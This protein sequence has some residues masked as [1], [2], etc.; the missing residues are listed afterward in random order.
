MRRGIS[1]YSPHSYSGKPKV[2]LALI[3]RVL[4][5]ARPYKWWLLSILAITFSIA[6]LSLLTPL[7]LRDLIDRT[8]PDRDIQRLIWLAI[9]LVVIPLV[10]SALDVAHKQINARVG[11]GIVYDLRS[12][13]FSHLQ[14][15]SLSFFTRT[16]SGELF[17]RLNNDVTG[18]Q[19]AITKVYISIITSF[20]QAVAILAVM[21]SLEWRLTLISIAVV[22]LFLLAARKLG[23]RLREI[24]RSQLDT[25]AKMNAIISELLNV[26]G[27]LLV[28]LFGRSDKENKRF[29]ERA[30]GVRDIGIKRAVT[31]TLFFTSIGLL[32]SIGVALVYGIG[33]YLVIGGALTIGTIVALGSYLGKLYSSLQN[34][35]NAPV[36]FATSIVSFERVF[37][38]LDLPLDIK[39]KPNAIVLHNIKGRLEFENVGFSY[40]KDD[41]HPLSEVHRFG[42]TQDV[43]AVLSED[44]PALNPQFAQEPEP[45]K[46]ETRSQ[47]REQALE[48]I[49][50][51][52]EP[53]QLVALVG[54]S[55]A[56][57][58][59]LTYLIPRLYD[60]SSGRI[61]I[62]GID[63]K[64]T[65]LAS[66]SAQI[67][68]VTQETFLFHDTVLT[69]LLYARPDA[70]SEQV[71]AAARAANI[72]DFIMELPDRYE[73]LV[74]ERGYRLSG[75]EKQRMALAR[76]ILKDP[77]ILVLDEATSSLDS[78]SEALIQEAL[79]RV[80]AERTSIVIAHRL[81]TILSADQI[82][83]MNRGEIVERGTHSRLL[84][85][86]GVYSSLYETQFKQSQ[87]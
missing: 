53:G 3:K 75:G 39:E 37:E 56:G 14:N 81:S 30:A 71:K 17:S 45:E 36:D 58:T 32:S 47:A 50:F 70:S 76:V 46:L 61:L 27:A 55:G 33:G 54:P 4:K 10:T 51:C 65:N 57:K 38:V 48:G 52:A 29:Q 23:N 6:G 83:V 59:T 79:G 5:Y 25:V 20:V 66:L 49:S 69:N 35:T 15:M 1:T 43:G 2:D 60:P 74:G 18:A 67:G 40:P 21:V 87:Q 24:T 42:V 19:S 8:L 84:S 64:D 28:K 11:E 9:A 12:A 73:T 72:H 85:Q 80:M 77:R 26:S 34:L 16:K 22:P 44:L 62:D 63:I 68:M 82:L 41:R 78:E 13:L 7:I 31:G 86:R